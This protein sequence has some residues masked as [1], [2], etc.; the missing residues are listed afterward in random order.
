MKALNNDVTLAESKFI[1]YALS[2]VSSPEGVKRIREFLF[3][4]T[5]IQRNYCTL[6][7]CRRCEDGDWE[8]VKK[9]Y[10]LGLIDARQAFSK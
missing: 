8:V 5:Q 6:F 9:A 3:N 1:D 7:F 10:N 4:G 2:L